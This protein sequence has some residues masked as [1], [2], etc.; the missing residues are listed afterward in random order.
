MS[1]KGVL[2]E[3]QL[4]NFVSYPEMISKRDDLYKVWQQDLKN[5]KWNLWHLVAAINT[6]VPPLRLTA[7]E[8]KVI[9]TLKQPPDDENNYIWE[10]RDQAYAMVINYDKIENKRRKSAEQ[11]GKSSHRDILSL[12]SELPG[13]KGQGKILNRIITQSLE[14]HPRKYLFSGIRNQGEQMSATSYQHILK[15]MFAPKNLTQTMVRK[16]FVNYFYRSGLGYAELTQLAGRMRHSVHIAHQAYLKTNIPIDESNWGKMIELKKVPAP[17]QRK[18]REPKDPRISA[19]VYRDKNK[20]KMKAYRLANKEQINATR[21]LWSLNNGFV[22]H[23]ESLME[24]YDLIHNGTRY[25]RKV[26]LVIKPRSKKADKPE[27]HIKNV[28]PTKIEPDQDET[29]TKPEKTAYKA[30][31]KTKLSMLEVLQEMA[32]D[33]VKI[34]YKNISKSYGLTSSE[35]TKWKKFNKNNKSLYDKYSN[36]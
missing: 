1:A 36:L 10:Y 28:T 2:T 17:L 22:K 30:T 11:H 16:A 29:P 18:K 35:I 14:A 13:L 19:K 7:I 4:K 25:V 31:V 26:P 8:M 32:R 34:T 33:G 6:L 24:K 20:D 21:A 9:R 5:V 3:E 12:D 23:P 27:T 15:S